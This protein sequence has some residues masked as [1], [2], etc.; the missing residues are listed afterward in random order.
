MAP[1][2]APLPEAARGQLEG[3]VDALRLR[4]GADLIGV[5][6]HGSLVTGDWVP[7]KSDADLLVLRRTPLDAAGRSDAASLWLGLSIAFGP[8]GVEVHELVQDDVRR[9]PLRYDFHFSEAHRP[10]AAAVAAGAPAGAPFV[11][12]RDPELPGYLALARLAPPLFGPP[13]SRMWPEPARK[14]VLAGYLSD[15][16]GGC[17]SRVAPTPPPSS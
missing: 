15:W 6:R 4:H 2:P 14:L 16:G 13:A 10:R 9:D 7:G 3:V 12:G 5:Y 11:P 17:T 1:V 8:K